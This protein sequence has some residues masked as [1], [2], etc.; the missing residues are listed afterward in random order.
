MILDF[1]A[2]LLSL[3]LIVFG[4]MIGYPLGAVFERRKL[5]RRP[6]R[7]IA[8]VAAQT[9][10]VAVADCRKRLEDKDI[11]FAEFLEVKE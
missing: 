7:P 9:E 3:G 4:F 11:L 1:L 6:R 2:F 10:P 8:P 5:N